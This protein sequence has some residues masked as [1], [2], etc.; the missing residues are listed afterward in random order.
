MH[1]LGEDGWFLTESLEDNV[2]HGCEEDD[3]V[4]FS[5]SPKSATPRLVANP[6]K[7]LHRGQSRSWS[8]E[9]GKKKSLAAPPP[10]ALVVR[11]K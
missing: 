4:N 2:Q 5:I 11:R 1:Q 6:E 8:A 9:Q 10:P 7:L 3:G